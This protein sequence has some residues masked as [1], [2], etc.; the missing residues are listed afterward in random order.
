MIKSRPLLRVYKDQISLALNSKSNRTTG[1]TIREQL[2]D[3]AAAKRQLK[4]NNDLD[5]TSSMSSLGD[6]LDKEKTRTRPS[7]NGA[8]KAS[9]LTRN[10][11]VRKSTK[12]SSSASSR[13]SSRSGVGKSSPKVN[14]TPSPRVQSSRSPASKSVKSAAVSNGRTRKTP[15]TVSRTQTRRSLSKPAAS[16]EELSVDVNEQAVDKMMTNMKEQNF[17]TSSETQCSSTK[18]PHF[19][20]PLVRSSSDPDLLKSTMSVSDSNLQREPDIK[21]SLHRGSTMS[22]P[23]D[24]R[25][26]GPPESLR[27]TRAKPSRLS[28]FIHRLSRK[29]EKRPDSFDE[30]LEDSPAD[31]IAEE[32]PSKR[33]VQRAPVANKTKVGPAKDESGS[34][35]TSSTASSLRRSKSEA[36]SSKTGQAKNGTQ[37][38]GFRPR[39]GFGSGRFERGTSATRSG[40]WK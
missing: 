16:A 31:V 13:V 17:D 6:T 10:G 34:R 3:D 1:K 35:L 24:A 21:S 7:Q 15:E 32:K 14:N 12:S 19:P 22:L 27:S 8:S 33:R 29:G 25:K 38:H 30:S 37:Q 5:D 2:K 11:S 26:R 20:V 9:P 18:I 40:S 36:A 39:F 4:D 23:P 28:K